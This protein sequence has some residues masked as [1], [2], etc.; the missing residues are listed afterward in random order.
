VSSTRAARSRE[1]ALAAAAEFEVY[2]PV[3]LRPP[4]EL[5]VGLRRFPRR[6]AAY[7]NGCSYVV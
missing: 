6:V 1:F 4:A 3:G 7:W 2:L 5:H